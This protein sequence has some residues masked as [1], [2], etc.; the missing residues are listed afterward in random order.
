MDPYRILEPIYRRFGT[1]L[2]MRL[3]RPDCRGFER[4]PLSGP[5]IIVCNHVSYVDGP[6][7]AAAVQRA[8]GRPVRFVIYEPIYRLP[9]VHHFMRV[10][11]A[12]PIYP[13]RDKVKQ[14]L[15]DISLGLRAGDII[16]LFPEGRLTPT[17]GLMRFRPGI[18]FV[19][20]RDCVEVFPVA[21]TGLWGSIFSRKHQG[22]WRRFLPRRPGVP[23]V[24]R[25]G[26]GTPCGLAGAGMLQ[27]AVL[28]L[29]YS[30]TASAPEAGPVR[31]HTA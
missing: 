27:H 1:W 17:G 28:K 7:V 26:E 6:L 19:L 5:A 18:E 11:R 30:A 16:C 20:A 25:C 23:V 14:A 31:G 24:A 2:L 22:S 9:L 12:I 15:E 29:K 21:L 8:V 3:Y 13:S 4:I 10:N